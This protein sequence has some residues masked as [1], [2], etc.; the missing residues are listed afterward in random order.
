MSK[1]IRVDI[2][3]GKLRSLAGAHEVYMNIR[4]IK[5]LQDAGI[6][7]EG[8]VE[9][10]GVTSGKLVHWN[11]QRNGKRYLVYEWHPVNDMAPEEEDEEL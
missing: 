2:D 4:I 1:P 5:E 10:R 7:A 11:E 9:F 3:H 8:G 6:P